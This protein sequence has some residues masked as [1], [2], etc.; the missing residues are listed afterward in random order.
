MSTVQPEEGRGN[1]AAR[2]H[3][4]ASLTHWE[5]AASGWVARQAA[6]ARALGARSPTG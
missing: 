5:E 4:D 6:T 1:E 3:R 2:E